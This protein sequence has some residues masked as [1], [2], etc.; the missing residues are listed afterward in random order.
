MDTIIAQSTFN[1]DDL[2]NASGQ[3]NPGNQATMEG[4]G[5]TWTFTAGASKNYTAAELTVADTARAGVTASALD[6]AAAS[7]LTGA[8]KTEALAFI[9]AAR[10]TAGTVAMTEAEFD[11]D[12]NHSAADL[13]ALNAGLTAKAGDAAYKAALATAGTAVET[14]RNVVTGISRAGNGFATTE[15]SINQVDLKALASGFKAIADA[16]TTGNINDSDFLAKALSATNSLLNGSID[17]STKLGQ[18]EKSIENQQEFLKNLT[19]TLDTGVGAM[20]DADMEA[21]AARLQALQVQ[22]QLATQSLSI[23]NEG[24]QNL[25]SLF[26]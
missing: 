15:I 22:Q 17:A 13:A 9:N 2:V 16:A 21:E 18:S 6:G 3:I 19:D 10:T 14:S 1:G 24:P 12:T 20:V 5:G 23:A 8:A 4:T 7:A 11:T 26:R 25:L